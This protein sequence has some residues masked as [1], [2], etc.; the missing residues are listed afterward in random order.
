MTLHQKDRNTLVTLRLQR[1][2][3]AISEAKGNIQM[4]YWRVVANR[5]YY[6]CYYAV[7]ALL[8]KNNLTAHTHAGVISQLGLHFVKNGI[9]SLEQGKL[10]RNLFEKRQTSDYNDWS[11]ISEQDITPFLEPAEKFIAEIENLINLDS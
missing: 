6:A 7:S 5:L 9:I 1:A 8:I 10:Y 4:G 11:T 2:K 3:E